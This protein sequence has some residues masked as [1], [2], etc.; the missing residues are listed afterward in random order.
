MS[1][2][3]TPGKEGLEL[4]LTVW[5]PQA[6]G[7]NR[8]GR[9]DGALGRKGPASSGAASW[10]VPAGEQPS[11]VFQ[12][13]SSE[14]T[15]TELFIAGEELCGVSGGARPV[16]ESK[17]PLECSPP[18]SGAPPCPGLLSSP[19]LLLPPQPITLFL[20]FTIVVNDA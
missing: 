9:E 6:P 14:G 12:I 15:G 5:V 20:I 4:Q 7:C 18:Q 1:L 3:A 2:A 17:S 10:D 8:E 19:Q 13:P 16:Q 11:P